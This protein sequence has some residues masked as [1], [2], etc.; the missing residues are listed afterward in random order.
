MLFWPQH[1]KDTTGLRCLQNSVEI[2]SRASGWALISTWL[3]I[4]YQ[5]GHEC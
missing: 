2:C 3:V 5:L 4:L 1:C